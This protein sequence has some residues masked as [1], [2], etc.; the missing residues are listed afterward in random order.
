M[1][2]IYIFC[3]ICI[4]LFLLIEFDHFLPFTAP[5]FA[6]IY[7]KDFLC[8]PIVLGLCLGC[9][10]LIKNKNRQ[11]FELLPVFVLTFIYSIYFEA[12]LP[13]FLNRYT[14]DGWDVVLYFLGTACFY[15]LQQIYLV[16]PIHKL[17]KHLFMK[18]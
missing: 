13:H 7:L 8:M 12:I 17:R 16:N 4:F 15:V 6:R 5:L 3:C 18:I 2:L 10:E 14:A 1:R 11:H 9:Y